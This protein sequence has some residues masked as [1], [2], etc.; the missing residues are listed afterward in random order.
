MFT[1]F[2]R[3]L[4]RIGIRRTT[5]PWPSEIAMPAPRR[6][7]EASVVAPVEQ[8]AATEP[9]PR[10]HQAEWQSELARRLARWHE[11]TEDMPGTPDAAALIEMLS[12]SGD[13]VIRQLPVAARDAIAYCD[14][15][16]IS[17]AHLAG[18]LGRDP[19]LVQALLRTANSAAM[20]AGRQPVLGLN[21]AIE[22]IGVLSTRTV[23]LANCVE[24]LLSR[25]GQP[26]EAMVNSVWE[27]MIRTGQIARTTAAAFEVD[28]E[29]AF[30]VS[31]LHDVGK[32]II[33]DQISTLRNKLRRPVIVPT[34][35][36]HGVLQTLHEPLGALA[37]LRWSM[38]ARAASAI[39]E[40]HRFRT[41]VEE[42][43]LAEVI[44][45]SER[46]DH[47]YRR[48]EP[49][50]IDAVFQSGRLSG[51]RIRA[52]QALEKISNAA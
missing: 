32:L 23:V 30:S 9:P 22:R 37:A 39:G 31:L 46:A 7:V 6:T 13:F 3:R 43:M 49:I 19:A 24:G 33:F 12:A 36:L 34:Q 29:E 18:R 40:H 52:S 26:Y 38:G 47:A 48:G 5:T 35:W 27:H 44:F 2:F 11:T 10:D 51:S 20:A 42:N 16:N 8:D 15:A 41:D 28:Q 50:D 25:P 17:R 21:G 4:F 45:T 1:Q 14:D